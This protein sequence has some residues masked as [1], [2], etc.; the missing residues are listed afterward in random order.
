MP[1]ANSTTPNGRA[2]LA[3]MLSSRRLTLTSPKPSS[4]SSRAGS[5]R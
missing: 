4:S 5:R 1:I 2:R 3:S